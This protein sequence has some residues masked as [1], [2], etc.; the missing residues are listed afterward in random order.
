[1]KNNLRF[2]QFLYLA[3]LASCLVN[4]SAAWGTWRHFLGC[5]FRRC[6]LNLPLL[7]V[8]QPYRW[9]LKQP[10]VRPP[11]QVSRS[12]EG[13]IDWRPHSVS[14][15]PIVCIYW[16]WKNKD[17]QILCL[18][19]QWPVASSTCLLGCTVWTP[20]QRNLK[21]DLVVLPSWV[22]TCALRCRGGPRT[23]TS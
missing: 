4:P 20:Y 16:K 6:N 1:M 5:I 19:R 8:K 22:S 13:W 15:S 10:M 17:S 11:I 3:A 2:S 21:T 14:K 9:S 7:S 18:S 23:L 12:G